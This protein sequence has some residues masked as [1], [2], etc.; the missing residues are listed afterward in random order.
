[1]AMMQCEPSRAFQDR[2]L[3]G[4]DMA[5]AFICEQCRSVTLHEPVDSLSVWLV[6]YVVGNHV[7]TSTF[8]SAAHHNFRGVRCPCT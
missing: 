5:I 2:L 6:L 8:Q 1:M 3:N 7:L 4:P